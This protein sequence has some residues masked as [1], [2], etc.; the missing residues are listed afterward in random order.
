[1]NLNRSRLSGPR[2]FG[3]D[4]GKLHQHRLEVSTVPT[5]SRKRPL[6]MIQ[7]RSGQNKR[8]AAFGK[9]SE[10]ELSSL[11]TK[12]NMTTETGQPVVFVHNIELDFN[13]EAINLA[14]QHP[15]EDLELKKLDA[16]VRA[17]DESL[18]PRD[19]YHHLAAV[20]PHLIR[21]YRV[22]I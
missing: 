11:I 9:D 4:I 5:A 18:L 2:I 8:F 22:R 7:S 3:L 17:Y 14:C 15:N 16:F 20:E 10:Q 1:M 19:G 6:S 12:Y 13:G 21:E